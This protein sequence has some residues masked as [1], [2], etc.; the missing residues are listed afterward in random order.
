MKPTKKC[1]LPAWHTQESSKIEALKWNESECDFQAL[2]WHVRKKIARELHDKGHSLS[3]VATDEEI[4]Q[5]VRLAADSYDDR[6]RKLIG[7]EIHV[8]LWIRGF[9]AEKLRS[10]P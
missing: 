10:L 7:L 8:T 5:Q 1:R 9:V 4:R 2:Y 3:E 6:R